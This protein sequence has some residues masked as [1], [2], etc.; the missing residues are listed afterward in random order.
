M[1]AEMSKGRRTGSGWKAG[2][3]HYRRLL[4]QLRNSA[5]RSMISPRN[6]DGR[7]GKSVWCCTLAHPVLCLAAAPPAGMSEYQ[8]QKLIHRIEADSFV[9]TIAWR[10]SDMVCGCGLW[11]CWQ[12]RDRA[13]LFYCQPWQS[14]RLQRMC[15]VYPSRWNFKGL[16]QRKEIDLICDHHSY[17][18]M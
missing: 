3:S 9:Q 12:K 14:M 2:T 4:F 15:L 16:V 6:L 8:G 18:C 10:M 13:I 17:V 7:S 1:M 11:M 5:S